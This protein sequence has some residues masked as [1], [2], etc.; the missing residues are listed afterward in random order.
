MRNVRLGVDPSIRLTE[1]YESAKLLY[2]EKRLAYAELMKLTSDYEKLVI[3]TPTLCRL[4]KQK[5]HFANHKVPQSKFPNCKTSRN[6][7]FTKQ[8]LI[9]WD[10]LITPGIGRAQYSILDGNS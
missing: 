8:N 1:Q 9:V 4:H 2:E 5:S 3:H 6:R 10:A 7:C